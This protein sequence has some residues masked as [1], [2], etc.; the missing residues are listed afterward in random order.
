MNDSHHLSARLADADRQSGLAEVLAEEL[1]ARIG[2][3]WVLVLDGE[4][5]PRARS[6]TCPPAA[7]PG[8]QAVAMQGEPGWRAVFE[9]A[10]LSAQE[11]AWARQA[12]ELTQL[13]WMG[14]RRAQRLSRAAAN[15]RALAELGQA[16]T[17]ERGRAGTARFACLACARLVA[18]DGVTVWLRDGETLTLSAA[19]GYPPMVAP[20]P[21]RAVPV[22]G[23][24]AE[25]CDTRRV[26]TL[27]AS[28]LPELPAKR[29]HLTFAPVGERA[30]NRALI[31]VESDDEPGPEEEQLLLG[32]GDQTLLSLENQR[33]LE[34]R[35]RTLDE[36]LASLGRALEVRHRH[37]AEHSD[38]LVADCRV[39]GGRLGLRGDELT[40][41][42]RA[43]ALHDLGKIGVPER[44]LE[45]TGAL[46]EEGWRRIRDH[47]E[48]GA[49]IIEP[50]AALAGVARLVGSC[51]EHWDGS[52]YPA[53][54]VDEQ[55]PFGSRIILCVDA[56]HAMCEDRS[57]QS[58][59]T[60]EEARQRLV[61]LAG[62]HFD[63]RVVEAFLALL[64]ERA[65]AA[66]GAGA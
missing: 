26:Q 25:I 1:R 5:Q 12:M 29:P 42:V 30:G 14:L 21:G 16:L 52:G 33:L 63:P 41:L 44:V 53:G 48:L 61:E 32:I 8:A 4:G 49:R 43:A 27:D 15:A 6:G 47:P 45:S 54:L 56:Y 7:P 65:A 22:E 39:L 64:A 36:L 17:L 28:S 38:H 59:R 57:Y 66:N 35:D 20:Q 60:P 37:T 3:R 55:I 62:V 40:D 34:E 18:G 31:V 46:D 9:C 51:H 24:L 19:A 2:A 11:Q 58:A 50:V 23:V 10:P 13:A